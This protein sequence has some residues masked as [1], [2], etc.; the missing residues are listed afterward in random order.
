MAS[1]VDLVASIV[2]QL[3]DKPDRV[4]A[5]WLENERTVEI[6]VDREDRGKVIGRRGKTVDSLRI[7]TTA[8]FANTGERIDIRLREE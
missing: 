7:L 2:K 8:V 1:P 4:E 3:V 6:N 5:R